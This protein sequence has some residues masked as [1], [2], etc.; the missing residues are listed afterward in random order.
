MKKTTVTKYE[1]SDGRTFGDE[2]LAKVHELD[3]VIDGLTEEGTTMT[4]AHVKRLMVTE[5]KA[6]IKV[7]KEIS[8]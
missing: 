3:L 1:T 5:P 2:A 8:E 4:A 6:F 7:L